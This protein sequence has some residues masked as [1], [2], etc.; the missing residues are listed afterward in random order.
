MQD[1]VER[2][3]WLAWLVYEYNSQIQ[4]DMTQLDIVGIS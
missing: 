1:K 2:R 4:Y 3:H